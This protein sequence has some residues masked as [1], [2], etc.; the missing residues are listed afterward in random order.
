MDMLRG[1]RGLRWQPARPD[2]HYDRRVLFAA[3]DGS[4]LG[5][6]RLRRPETGEPTEVFG[7]PCAMAAV[8]GHD[9]VELIVHRPTIVRKAGAGRR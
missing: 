3:A 5:E 8:S 2:A 9:G 7:L 1:L 4:P 6:V